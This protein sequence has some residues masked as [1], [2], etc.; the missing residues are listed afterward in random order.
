MSGLEELLAQATP[1]PWEHWEDGGSEGFYVGEPG[2]GYT[3]NM[4]AQYADARLIALAPA[5]VRLLIDMAAAMDYG[6]FDRTNDTWRCAMCDAPEGHADGCSHGELLA[7]FAALDQRVQQQSFMERKL[8]AQR[9]DI[10]R[11]AARVEA[12][13]AENTRLREQ[14]D[15]LEL[16]VGS[17]LY[18]DKARAAE[19]R[20]ARLQQALREIHATTG[21]MPI[22]LKA[23][24]ALAGLDTPADSQEGKT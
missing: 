4:G 1:G 5:A 12:A 20:C 15:A 10:E 23:R 9:E 16:A 6:Y 22:L 8:V 3:V 19:A 13:E 24:E 2:R 11:L 14:R 18:F 7:R 17:D 21:E